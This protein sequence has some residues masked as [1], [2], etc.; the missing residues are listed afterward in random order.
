MLRPR[1]TYLIEKWDRKCAYCDA[2]NIPLQ[3]EH[4]ESRARGGSNRAS[5]LTLACEP[6]NQRKNSSSALEMCF[7]YG[8]KAEIDAE[9]GQVVKLS[10]KRKEVAS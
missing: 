8:M 7:P 2:E 5:N 3:I 9:K 1:E 4:I 10:V 6:C